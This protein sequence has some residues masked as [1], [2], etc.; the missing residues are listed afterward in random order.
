MLAVWGMGGGVT[1]W[2]CGVWGGGSH[3]GCRVWG[4]HVD[5]VGYS[6]DGMM[7]ILH[8]FSNGIN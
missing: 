2:L 4:S 5:C 8:C 6:F 3:V 7:C 1:C